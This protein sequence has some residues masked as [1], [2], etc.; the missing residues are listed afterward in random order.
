[1][2]DLASKMSMWDALLEGLMPAQ[3]SLP[4]LPP[5]QEAPLEALMPICFFHIRERGFKE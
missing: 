5:W 3:V 1:M 2:S 4:L